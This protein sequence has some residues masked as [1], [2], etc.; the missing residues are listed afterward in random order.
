MITDQT[1][2]SDLPLRTLRW[3]PSNED[4]DKP[5]VVFLHGLGDSAD[6]WRPVIDAWPND[7]EFNAIAFDLPGHGGSDWME[8]GQYSAMSIAAAVTDALLENGIDRPILIGHSLG[9]RV[10]LEIAADGVVAPLLCVLVDMS[11]DGVTG[12]PSES[13]MI[14]ADH[15]DALIT[16]A[17]TADDLVTILADRL[18]LADAETLAAVTKAQLSAHPRPSETRATVS[19]DPEVKSLVTTVRRMDAWDLLAEAMCPVAIIRGQFSGVL[20]RQTAIRM[21]EEVVRCFADETIKLAGHAIALEQPKA[22][23]DALAR[24]VNQRLVAIS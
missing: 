9:A 16:G 4:A 5:V 3:T 7:R 13:Q 2:P 21:S 24:V 18:P 14:V 12:E 11:P 17:D 22:L 15:I 23:A 6:I 8:P 19:L 1:T 10:A 20:D